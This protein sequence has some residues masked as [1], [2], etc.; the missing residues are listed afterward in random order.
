MRLK[1]AVFTLKNLG[2]CTL[3]VYIN[4]RSHCF[5]R[6]TPHPFPTPREFSAGEGD[7]GGGPRPGELVQSGGSV[8]PDD[9]G[10]Q[11]A[12]GGG[13]ADGGQER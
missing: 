2:T 4:M 3:G 10:G 1:T 13:A 12:A 7:L 11:W 6:V 8:A 5:T 9:G